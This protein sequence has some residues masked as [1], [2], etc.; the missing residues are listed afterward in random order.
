MNLAIV[1]KKTLQVNCLKCKSPTQHEVL[2]S[3]S[4]TGS[5]E[6]IDSYRL[7]LQIIRCR[8]C[9]NIS[10]K[11]S[12]WNSGES[13]AGDIPN[14]PVAASPDPAQRRPTVNIWELPDR[15][16]ALYKETLTGFNAMAMTLSAVGLRSVVEAACLEQGYTHLTLEM[17]V[18]ELITQGDFLKRDADYLLTHRFLVDGPLLAIS[19]PTREEFEIALQILEHLLTT[20]Y[21]LPRSDLNLH[22]LRVTQGNNSRAA[23]RT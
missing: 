1:P 5:T 15:V 12:A 21:V 13:Y 10:F 7:E 17:K 2:R 6:Q 18:Q 22:R 3:Q 8:R 4:E 9:Q 16:C 14:E 23:A 20:L 11:Q 19:T